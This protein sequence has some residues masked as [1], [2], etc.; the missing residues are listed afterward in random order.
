M[1]LKSIRTRAN[2]S[3]VLGVIPRE[4]CERILREWV[5]LPGSWPLV[6]DGWDA[7]K[8]FADAQKRMQQRYA[9]LL[10]FSGA[11][12]WKGTIVGH[13]HVRE[14][15][16]RAWDTRD[17]REREWICFRIRD[18]YASMVR[19]ADMTP[20]EMIKDEENISGPRY[21]APPVTPFEAVIFYF[22]HQGTRARRCPNAECPAPYFFLS[23]KG[24]EYCS[25]ECARPARLESQ[26]R[27]WNENRGKSK[28]RQQ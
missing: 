1:K 24:Q 22:Q 4:L 16:R 28:R 12:A 6:N 17:V 7:T 13:L 10:G 5:N 3:L 27:W 8:R 15:L 9:K 21:A 14:M 11:D 23:K 19:R 26:R 20:E 18:S 2:Q 25:P